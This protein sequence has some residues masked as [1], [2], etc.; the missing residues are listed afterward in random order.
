M[1]EK[2]GWLLLFTIMIVATVTGFFGVN[3]A[4]YGVIGKKTGFALAF[5]SLVPIYFVSLKFSHTF[6][7]MFSILIVLGFIVTIAAPLIFPNTFKPYAFY[8]GLYL[9][10]FGIAMYS[11][12]LWRKRTSF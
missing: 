1:D 12:T 3:L 11:R 8:N 5:G 9:I 6:T 2:S 4:V 7:D 10:I